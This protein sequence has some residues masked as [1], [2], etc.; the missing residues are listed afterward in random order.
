MN[1]YK[2]IFIAGVVALALV[3]LVAR[4]V[5]AAPPTVAWYLL[6]LDPGWN[7]VSL[8][9]EPAVTR[10]GAVLDGSRVDTVLAYNPLERN[11]WQAAIYDD[12]RWRGGLTTIE[13]GRGYWMHSRTGGRVWVLLSTKT[14]LTRQDVYAGWNLVGVGVRAPKGE[15]VDYGLWDDIEWRVAYTFRPSISTWEKVVPDGDHGL[16]VG[17]GYWMWVTVPGCLCP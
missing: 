7:L 12:G 17:H 9:E 10:I 15:L 3:L 2:A 1:E 14:E 13:S 8:P 5:Y 16:R 4:L 11:E 6:P